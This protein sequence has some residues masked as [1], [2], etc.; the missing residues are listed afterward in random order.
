MVWR[1]QVQRREVTDAVNTVSPVKRSVQE[2]KRK[3]FEVKFDAKKDD[4]TTRRD[5]RLQMSVL[6]PSA[7]EPLWWRQRRVHMSANCAQ[8]EAVVSPARPLFIT[9]IVTIQDA[10]LTTHA[11]YE[12]DFN[13]PFTFLKKP[14]LKLKY[15]NCV[16]IELNVYFLI[17]G[18]FENTYFKAKEHRTQYGANLWWWQTI[19]RRTPYLHK[20][21]EWSAAGVD[22]VC[23][24]EHFGKFPIRRKLVANFIRN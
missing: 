1:G 19:F 15:V 13:N 24:Y 11:E 17:W 3:W 21:Y 10:A 4:C 6:R 23:S 16:L 9:I 22:S 2:M 8:D 18:H 12:V 20:F 7:V 14:S 5:C